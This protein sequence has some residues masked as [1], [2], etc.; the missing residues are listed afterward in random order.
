M[1]AI[2]ELKKEIRE[3]ESKEVKS[4]SDYCRLLTLQTKIKALS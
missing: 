3:I 4:I 1:N 2:K